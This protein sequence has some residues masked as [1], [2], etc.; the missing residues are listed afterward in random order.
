MLRYARKRVA[1][2]SVAWKLA[3]RQVQRASIWMNLLII[4]IMVLTF[5][6][7]VVVTGI[8][9]GLLQGSLDANK[10]LYTGNVIV[11]EIFGTQGIDNTQEILQTL[12]SSPDVE[13]YSVRYIRQA[14]AEANYQ[15]RRDFNDP[16]N[17]LSLSF[18]G[19]DPIAEDEAI[20]LSESLIEGEYLD[21]NES[22]YILLGA[23]NVEKY[24]QFSDLFDPLKNVEAGSRVK[25]TFTDSNTPISFT[26]SAG[27]FGAAAG[28]IDRTGRTKEFIV[29]GIIDSKVD[30]IALRAF[31]TQADWES[32]VSP[33]LDEASEIAI[34]TKGSITDDQY[35]NELRGYG[36]D[37][38]SKIQTAEE[39]IP[40]VLNDLIITFGLLGNITGAVAVVVSG[41]TIFVV[42]YINALTRRKQ[43]GILK[44]IGIKGGAIERAYIMQSL[45]YAVIGSGIGYAIIFLVLVPYF[46]ENPIDFPFS[47]GIL[48]VTVEGTFVR[49]A[50]LVGVTA[51]AGYIPSWLIVRKNTLDSILGR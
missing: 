41:I 46:Q 42:I 12:E 29:K 49:A 14:V 31:V 21:P 15:T 22:G 1:M 16:E 6:N 45:F 19:I 48:F 35:A 25:I 24:S 8:L 50:I 39:A 36:F 51:I 7:L 26:E 3:F 30:Q 18:T 38:Y 47:D 33:R 4:L 32:L 17:S 44:G 20:F 10:K 28:G 40:N 23:L 43:I 9:I 13:R 11:S 2:W 34:V 5:L 37:E 27:S